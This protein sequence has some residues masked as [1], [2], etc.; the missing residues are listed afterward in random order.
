MPVKCKPG[1]SLPTCSPLPYISMA[2]VSDEAI[3]SQILWKTSQT[4]RIK[5]A[6]LS[7]GVSSWIYASILEHHKAKVQKVEPRN[8]RRLWYECQ[9]C[10][11]VGPMPLI[12][13]RA[14]PTLC[15]AVVKG[16]RVSCECQRKVHIP[17]EGPGAQGPRERSGVSVELLSNCSLLKTRMWVFI[18]VS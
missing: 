17:I 13:Q 4:C 18:L 8:K 14:L 12:G 2:Q 9:Q 15:K 11:A 6:A 5:V 3:V 10:R 1:S 7:R 16:Q